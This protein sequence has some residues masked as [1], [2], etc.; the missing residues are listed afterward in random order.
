M[1]DE[2]ELA[3]WRQRWQGSVQGAGAT[4]R[5]AMAEAEALKQRVL[6]QTRR[7]RRV[8]I[9]PF[10]VTAVVGGGVLMRALSSERRLDTILA[11]EAWAFIV[12]VWA[13]CAWIARGT[14]QPLG[15][16]TLDFLRLAIRRCRA[17]IHG[18]W[19]GAAVYVIQ[20]VAVVLLGWRYGGPEAS[21]AAILGSL[22]L[23]LSGWIGLPLYLAF[24]LWYVARKRSEMAGYCALERELSNASS[25]E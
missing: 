25:H 13:S 12:L 3:D 15:K 22:P 14:R 2:L 24:M 10:L 16:S 11:I 23:I 9:A 19:L 1:N 18:A 21:L 7:M 4:A 8:L 17:S 6:S 20:L 5:N